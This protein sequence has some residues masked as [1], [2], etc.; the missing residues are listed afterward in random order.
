MLEYNKFNTGISLLD[1][2]D[3]NLKTPLHYTIELKNYELIKTLLLYNANP[4][5]C[6]I[7]GYNFIKS[8]FN[9]KKKKIFVVLMGFFFLIILVRSGFRKKKYSIDSINRPIECL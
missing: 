8:T 5:F 9:M 7:N 2:Q 1:I 4:N 3:K 6:D